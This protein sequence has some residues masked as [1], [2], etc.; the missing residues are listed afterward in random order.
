MMRSAGFIDLGQRPQG[1]SE[2]AVPNGWIIV[3]LAATS[4]QH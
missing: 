4:F 2:A 3:A 1:V